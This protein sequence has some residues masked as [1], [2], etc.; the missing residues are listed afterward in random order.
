MPKPTTVATY[1]AVAGALAV[2]TLY[3][4]RA[5]PAAGLKDALAMP[6]ALFGTIGSLEGLYD[7]P[8]GAWANVCVV[9][10]IV[11][12]SVVWWIILRT[13]VRLRSQQHE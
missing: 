10:N 13:V 8:S 11:T 2:G 3:A 5:L 4:I 6:G 1:A 12:Y 9:G 7:V